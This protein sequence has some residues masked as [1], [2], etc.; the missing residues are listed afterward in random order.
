MTMLPQM[1]YSTPQYQK[2]MQEASACATERGKAMQSFQAPASEPWILAFADDEREL[3]Q[4]DTATKI[5]DGYYY[6]RG[7]K[8]CQAKDA[9]TAQAMLA[10]V[11]SDQL[12]TP[13]KQICHSMQ[14]ELK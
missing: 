7:A 9:E 6:G 11:K 1:G 5:V 14:I 10:K 12:R 3:G 4:A 8:A 13:L 2:Y